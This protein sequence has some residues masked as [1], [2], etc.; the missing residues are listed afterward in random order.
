MDADIVLE[1]ISCRRSNV[2]KVNIVFADRE[3]RL[4]GGSPADSRFLLFTQKSERHVKRKC[5]WESI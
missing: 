2:G 4:W 1:V 3:E 5:P